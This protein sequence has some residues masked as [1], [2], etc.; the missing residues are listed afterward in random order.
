MLRFF[1]PRSLIFLL[2]LCSF[3]SL[4][5]PTG[6][7]ARRQVAKPRPVSVYDDDISIADTLRLATEYEPAKPQKPASN[8]LLESGVNTPALAD[9]VIAAE[10]PANPATQESTPATASLTYQPALYSQPRSEPQQTVFRSVGK[11][12]S[13]PQPK[14]TPDKAESDLERILNR[15]KQVN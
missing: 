7:A 8:T 4:A 9:S 12:T 5:Q 3:G 6:R 14:P 13:S 1:S 10:T 2:M 11:R 15:K